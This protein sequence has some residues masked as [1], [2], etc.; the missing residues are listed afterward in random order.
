VRAANG[1]QVALCTTRRYSQTTA[2]HVGLVRNGLYGS[3]YRIFHVPYPV[4][5]VPRGHGENHDYLVGELYRLLDAARGA[6]TSDS[7]L[8]GL[9]LARNYARE[10]N[11]YARCFNL[12]EPVLSA[13]P[14]DISEI[15]ERAERLN[16]RI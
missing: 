11:E 2:C 9:E 3:A 6:R 8:V 14:P 13:S 5:P 12:D 10:A 15:L 7:I 16:H 4:L 1:E